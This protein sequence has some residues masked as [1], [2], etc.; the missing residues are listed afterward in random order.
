MNQVIQIEKDP[1]IS[2][3]YAKIVSAL[4]V[5][6]HHLHIWSQ[7]KLGNF[8]APVDVSHCRETQL[9]VRESLYNLEGTGLKSD[10]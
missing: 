7:I 4:R 10:I 3:V 9:Q 5:K 6:Q 1:L 8:Q 2:M